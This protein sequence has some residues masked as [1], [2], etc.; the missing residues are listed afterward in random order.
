MSG[1]VIPFDAGVHK[2]VDALLPWY[3]NGTLSPEEHDYVHKH[4]GACVQCRREAEW[5]R[6]LHAACVVAGSTP[7]GAKAF[8]R[9]RRQLE[10][11]RPAKASGLLQRIAS[12]WTRWALAASVLVAV[13]AIPL[14]R[15]SDA[16]ALYRSLAAPQ[17]VARTG[18]LIVVFDPATTE[19]DLRGALRKA[20]ARVVDGPTQSNA[21]VLDVARERRDEAVRSLRSERSVILVEP[22][23]SE[24]SP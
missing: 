9:L 23:S 21:Y 6:G 4:V 19:A 1:R 18:S 24:A 17:S 5:L 8:G 16:P 10:A 20:R 14:M 12:P 15:D 3:V 22:L 11:S 2:A 13:L 7:A